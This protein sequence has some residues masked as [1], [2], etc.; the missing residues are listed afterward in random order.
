MSLKELMSRKEQFDG[1][2]SD[3]RKSRLLGRIFLGWESEKLYSLIT[4]WGS[5]WHLN[6]EGQIQ[7]IRKAIGLLDSR[8]IFIF[9][10]GAV[11]DPAEHSSP[12]MEQDLFMVLVGK[13]SCW[14]FY[15]IAICD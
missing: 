4:S 6:I 5:I 9:T 14:S 13:R 7:A 15:R 1:P 3:I 8:G 11:E 10:A 2:S 12:C